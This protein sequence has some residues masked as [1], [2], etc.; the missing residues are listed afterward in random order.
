MAVVTA[1]HVIQKQEEFR[2]VLV[3]ASSVAAAGWLVTIGIDPTY[4]ET[5]YG[6]IERGAALDSANGR[7]VYRV[8]RFVEKPHLA[9][10]EEY[11]RRGTFSWNSG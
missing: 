1:D 7:P 5:G 10:A 4:A 3:A 6:Y 2:D 9:L 11:V 8:A